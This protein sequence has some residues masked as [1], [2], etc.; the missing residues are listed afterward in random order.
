MCK[1]AVPIIWDRLWDSHQKTHQS[2]FLNWWHWSRT[3]LELCFNQEN[4][5]WHSPKQGLITEIPPLTGR[6][7]LNNKGWISDP[8][9]SLSFCPF[10]RFRILS[11]GFKKKKKIQVFLLAYVPRTFGLTAR[12]FLTLFYPKP[13]SD[14]P[15]WVSWRNEMNLTFLTIC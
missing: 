13:R 14:G 11:A 15:L 3:V 2:A 12:K 6:V 8:K 10:G 7:M 4:Y 1:K 9:R 5:S